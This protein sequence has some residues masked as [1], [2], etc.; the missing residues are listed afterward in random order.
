MD[1]RH[2]KIR[3]VYDIGAAP[4]IFQQFVFYRAMLLYQRPEI[5]GVLAAKG[6]DVLVVVADGNHAHFVVGPHERPR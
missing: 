3:K 5:F 2:E 1:S 4:V 6:V